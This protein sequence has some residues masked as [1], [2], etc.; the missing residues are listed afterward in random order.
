MKQLL[1]GDLHITPCPSGINTN[2]ATRCAQCNR[3]GSLAAGRWAVCPRCC[4][5][6]CSRH[7]EEAPFR[8]CSNFC[9]AELNDYVGGAV[10]GASPLQSPQKRRLEDSKL[11]AYRK[12][13]MRLAYMHGFLPKLRQ[14]SQ[15]TFMASPADFTAETAPDVDVL[16]ILHVSPRDFRIRFQSSHHRYY[17]DGVQT[18]G[19]VMSMTHAFSNPF[20]SDTVITGMIDGRTWPRA[21]YLKRDVSFTAMS[22][23]HLLCPELLDL[24]AASPRNDARISHLL[25]EL[26]QE[27]EIAVNATSLSP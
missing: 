21:G 5:W 15:V 23:D 25:R 19:S 8:L 10:S 7:V 4:A 12:R 20:D 22:R 11:E 24:Y 9:E 18:R 2:A 3:M 1:D 16:K 6:V 13:S 14:T 26:S 27:H 17:I